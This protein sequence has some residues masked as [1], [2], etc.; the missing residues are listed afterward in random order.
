MI[1]S[2]NTKDFE[3][4]LSKMSSLASKGLN[5]PR[6]KAENCIGLPHTNESG[7][8]LNIKCPRVK[9]IS[10]A[11]GKSLRYEKP[12]RW[13]ILSIPLLRR[14]KLLIYGKMVGKQKKCKTGDDGVFE[15]LVVK[16]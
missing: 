7:S 4:G 15:L 9:A 10:G 1:L 3:S 8:D 14:V 6:Y 12:S 16:I 5:Y 2:L 11:T 13:V